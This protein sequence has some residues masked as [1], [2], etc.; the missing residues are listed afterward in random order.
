MP[1]RSPLRATSLLTATTMTAAMA[2]L[3]V[4]ASSAGLPGAAL[5]ASR[6]PTGP[7]VSRWQ[8][9]NGAAIDWAK[10]AAACNS[11]AIIKATESDSYTNPYFAKDWAATPAAGL[12][13][14]AYL[15][16]R[17]HLPVSTAVSQA[18][19]YATVVGSLKHA[20][21]LPPILD[22]E[23]DG[24][25]SPASLITWAQTVLAEMQRRT[26]RTPV[27]YTYRYFWATAMDNTHALARYPLWIA[28][29]TTGI[30]QPHSPLVGSWP[31][32]SLWQYTASARVSG[33]SGPVDMS[34][35]NG[36][37]TDLASF[38]DG[39]APRTLAVRAPYA[40]IHVSASTSGSTVNVSWEPNDNGGALVTRSTVTASPGGATVTVD[41]SSH[42]ASFTGLRP[43]TSYR[44]TVRATNAA[45]LSSVASASSNSVTPYIPMALRT[46]GTTD[47][48]YGSSTT[49]SATLRRSD[50]GAALGSRQVGVYL[51]PA[52]KSSWSLLKTKTTSSTGAISVYLRPRTNE[53]VQ[54]RVAGGS[55]YLGTTVTRSIV[56][57]PV[58]TA[59]LSSTTVRANHSVTM[60]GT[61]SPV[62]A[63]ATVYRQG[64]Y[65]GGWHTWATAKVRT[66]GTFSF[67]I[68]P[69]VKTTDVYRVY[70]PGRTSLGSASSPRL[71]LKVS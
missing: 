26:G 71:Y 6:C 9:P 69:T 27:I 30:A 23:E 2:L 46:S 35:F 51:R 41:G 70:L 53:A 29:Y 22:L 55:G 28:D 42:V 44:F 63:G 61:V 21:D 24:G 57:R 52:G 50:T 32:W 56:V 39:T 16:A 47:L 48:R 3:G 60:R 65:D 18:D 4:A 59:T 68:T 5:A 8:H 33:I 37:L 66:D 40:P 62:L 31:T 19:R 25:L 54:F 11:F 15:Y 14:G 43:G 36:T 58:L 34:R 12:Y 45:G 20:G 49:L 10:V 67:T 7:D 17:P 1:R 13:R 38:A 64:Y